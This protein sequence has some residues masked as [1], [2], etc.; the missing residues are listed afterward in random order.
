[1]ITYT[2]NG[3]ATTKAISEASFLERRLWAYASRNGFNILRVRG[4]KNRYGNT[5]GKTFLGLHFNKISAYQQLKNPAKKIYFGK[6]VNV[7]T[8]NKGMQVMSVPHNLDMQDA[9]ESFEEIVRMSERH[10]A[11]GVVGFFRR[12]LG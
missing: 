1:M 9:F 8:T 6:K 11:R 10:N 3:S 4:I 7:G 12:L 2:N 5:K